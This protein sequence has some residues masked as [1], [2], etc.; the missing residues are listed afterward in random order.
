[1]S[2]EGPYNIE[3]ELYYECPISNMTHYAGNG[4]AG[5]Q[6]DDADTNY[7]TFGFVDQIFS[8]SYPPYVRCIYEV[9]PW[10]NENPANNCFFWRHDDIQQASIP[11]SGGKEIAY[12]RVQVLP[13]FTWWTSCV[14]WNERPIVTNPCP[15]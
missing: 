4:F 3:S 6:I 2:F 5:L 10:V 15:L 1:M 9:C 7:E 14:R 11:C 8:S 12:R 13:F